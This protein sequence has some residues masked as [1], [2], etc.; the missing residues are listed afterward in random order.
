MFVFSP[1]ARLTSVTPFWTGRRAFCAAWAS[2]RVGAVPMA[3]QAES[4]ENAI[5][6]PAPSP[7]GNFISLSPVVLRTMTSLSPWSG[8]IRQASHCP[9]GDNVFRPMLRKARIS[10]SSI[11]RLA[12][13]WAATGANTTQTTNK[14]RMAE[15][16]IR[17][18]R[19]LQSNKLTV[20]SNLVT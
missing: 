6:P 8:D 16:R 7:T 4:S 10:S 9:S 13:F 14:T 11:G 17:F 18:I 5:K 19:N 1:L 15:V 20:I 3:I 2:L 12:P